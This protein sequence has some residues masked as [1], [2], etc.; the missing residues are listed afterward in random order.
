MEYPQSAD[1]EIMCRMISYED[2]SSI[3][4]TKAVFSATEIIEKCSARRTII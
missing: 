1:K 4:R 2:I 3:D